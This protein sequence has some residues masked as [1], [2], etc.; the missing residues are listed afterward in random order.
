ML[1]DYTWIDDEKQW[2]DIKEDVVDAAKAGKLFLIQAKF[3]DQYDLI[4]Q[5][6]DK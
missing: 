3:P 5:L 1:S 6:L 2:K 4:E